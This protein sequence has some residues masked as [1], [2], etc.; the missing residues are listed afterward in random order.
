MS[1]TLI[2]ASFIL[3]S[4]FLLFALF[5]RTYPDRSAKTPRRAKSRQQRLHGHFTQVLSRLR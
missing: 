5:Q 1:A 4:D 3:A 2:F